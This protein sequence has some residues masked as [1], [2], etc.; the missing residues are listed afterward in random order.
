MAD[1]PMHILCLFLRSGIVV[2]TVKVGQ[3]TQKSLDNI[4]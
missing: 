4:S 1:D 3:S 2:V